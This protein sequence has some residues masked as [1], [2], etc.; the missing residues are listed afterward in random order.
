MS[1]QSSATTTST[2]ASRKR[3]FALIGVDSAMP[4]PKRHKI[5]EPINPYTLNAMPDDLYTSM[6]R[7]LDQQSMGRCAAASKYNQMMNNK[8]LLREHHIVSNRLRFASGKADQRNK[9]SN[10]PQPTKVTVHINDWQQFCREA[11]TERLY[12]LKD[13][14]QV[15]FNIDFTVAD[16][17]AQAY[18]PFT[19][20]VYR[21]EWLSKVRNFRFGNT[22]VKF[23]FNYV[24]T[25]AAMDESQFRACF[26]ALTF[27]AWDSIICWPCPG[28]QDELY[29]AVD[30]FQITFKLAQAMPPN[31]MQRLNRLITSRCEAISRYIR[32]K[33]VIVIENQN[34]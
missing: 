23:N 4:A 13:C 17:T 33:A 27:A 22:L 1:T 12:V 34:E 7:Y 29:K 15:N 31:V 11:S 24:F 20:H 5:E 18:R 25:L 6:A 2:T 16:A 19:M 26:D 14:E 9:L 30:T 28:A 10:L 3:S 8:L 32:Q 21:M